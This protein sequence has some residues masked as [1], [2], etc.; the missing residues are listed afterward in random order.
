M[1]IACC[2][3]P[4]IDDNAEVELSHFNLLRSVGKGAFGKV[5]VVQHKGTK[6]IYALKYI[7]KAKC[8]QMS[9]VDNIIEE[10]KLLEAIYSN[11]VCNLRYAFQDDENLFMVL[12][13]MLGGDLRFHLDRMGAFKED[14]ISLVVAEISCSLSY[15][16]S[17]NIIHRDLKPDNILLDEEGHAHLADFN[18][19]TR[20]RDDK[21][22]TAVAGSMAYMAPEILGKKGYFASID[23][24]SL[25]IIIYEMS[26]AKRPFRAKTNEGL[27]NAILHEEIPLD[28]LSKLSPP[29]ID[30]I[31][32]FLDRDVKK[33]LGVKESGGLNTI[34]AHPFFASLDWPTVENKKAIPPFVPDAKKANFDATHELEELLLEDN[35]LKARPRKKKGEKTPPPANETPEERA[36]RL[37]EDNFTV[38][39]WT[40][41]RKDESNSMS[42]T[43]P[44][45]LCEKGNYVTE[46][47]DKP[48]AGPPN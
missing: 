11:F 19:A 48:T 38:F 35:P 9:A 33:R 43:D 46:V 30:L 8:M 32:K 44:V 37:M 17:K 22:L 40:K 12:D 6:C 47:K 4:V 21:P 1:G 7:N 31:T 23:W 14:H 34:K 18:I 20:F 45:D 26:T 41:I 13:L 36:Y 42:N 2:K 5:R 10:R 24:W 25:G 29:L 39:D 3:G 16:H 27:T 28:P 15:L